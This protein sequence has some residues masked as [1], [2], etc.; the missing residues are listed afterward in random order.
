[1]RIRL[2]LGKGW[3][4]YQTSIV[5]FYSTTFTKTRLDQTLRSYHRLLYEKA[6]VNGQWVEASSGKTFDVFNPST[7]EKIGCV[8]DMNA[9]DTE[10]AIQCASE[11]FETWKET[12]AKER[13]NILRRWVDLCNENKEDLAKI[14]TLEMGKPLQESV[15][16]LNYGIGFLEWFAEEARRVYGDIIPS[17]AKSKK[18][19]VLKQPIGVTGMITPWNFP[20]AM[21]TRKAGPAIAAG[22]TVVL[23]PAEDTPY[24]ALALCELAEKAGLPPGVLNVVT[25]SRDNSA[26][27]G[28]TLCKSPTIKQISFTGSTAVGKILLEQSASTVK[29]VSLENGGNAPFIVYESADID[30]AVTG[31]MGSKFR[32]TGQACICANRI[33]VQDSIYETFLDALSKRMEQE[34][35]IGDGFNS[36][37][38]QGPLI[39]AR[40]VEK[41]DHLVQD[42]KSNGAK[43]LLGGQ[44]KEGNFYEPTLSVVY[45]AIDVNGTVRPTFKTEEEAIYLA[46]NTSSGLAGYVFTENISQMWRIAEKLEFGI[47]GV[48]EGLP[49]MPEAI[50]GGWKESGL[51]REG[52]KY[53]LEDYLEIKY[54]CMGGLE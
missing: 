34:L 49:A 45:T 31:V 25:C 4:L 43:I 52:G 30:K 6:Y 38:T 11:A 37:S 2:L 42:A 15:G 47:V 29:R 36:K 40:A 28:K 3:N 20:H 46:N 27:V 48:N 24:S 8:P 13:S 18:M 44:R 54:V 14:L 39:N 17:P 22:C 51:G 26:E 35:H 53:G 12:T 7:Q 1:M 19:L 9:G 41:I 32:N 10:R 33:M 16:E 21:I 50:F 23:K 5:P